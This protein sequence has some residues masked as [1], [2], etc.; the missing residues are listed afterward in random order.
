MM[1]TLTSLSHEVR[2]KD[3]SFYFDLGFGT[4]MNMVAPV[5]SADFESF[6]A[7]T[8]VSAKLKLLRIFGVE[9]GYTPSLESPEAQSGGL[10]GK[11]ALSLALHI[12]PT[13]PLGLYI[14]AGVDSHAL[15][16]LIEF[17]SPDISYHGGAGIDVHVGDH[18]V[19]NAE[20]LLLVSGIQGRSNVR[21]SPTASLKAV[22]ANREAL[23]ESSAALA[24]LD[25]QGQVPQDFDLDET[26]HTVEDM[27]KETFDLNSILKDA[28]YQVGL[29][30]RYS[31]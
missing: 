31:F 6:S 3:G 18:W 11:V 27:M 16:K 7:V 23:L 8:A 14:K 22:L 25:E 12:M 24:S 9:F 2:A 17:G 5:T 15:N 4:S 28:R 19:L 29:T 30:F 20:S 26:T 21:E 13:T 10:N 1:L